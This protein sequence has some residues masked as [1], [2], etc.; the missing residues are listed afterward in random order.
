MA[1]PEQ[2]SPPKSGSQSNWQFK[3]IV[4][5]IALGVLG[6]LAKLFGLM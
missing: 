3:F 5:V 1:S 4:A 2:S 6:I